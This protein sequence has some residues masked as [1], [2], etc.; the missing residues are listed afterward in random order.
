M[1]LMV[2]VAVVIM[3]MM[4]VVVEM[5][6]VVLMMSLEIWWR[7]VYYLFCIFALATILFLFIFYIKSG[8]FGFDS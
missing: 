6:E 2:A 3:M 4:M 5:V 7:F 8:L 1:T